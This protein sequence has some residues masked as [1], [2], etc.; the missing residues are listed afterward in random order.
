MKLLKPTLPS[1]RCICRTCYL[2][3]LRFIEFGGLRLRFIKLL[4][5]VFTKFCGVAEKHLVPFDSFF[6][7]SC[8]HKSLGPLASYFGGASD[9][10]NFW[11]LR[12]I[13]N[14]VLRS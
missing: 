10:S 1:S 11:G 2:I 4:V 12:F 5:L 9:S 8:V 6:V 3:R 14:S 13:K 7:K